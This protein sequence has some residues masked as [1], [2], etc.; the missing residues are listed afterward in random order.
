MLSTHE[1][2]DVVERLREWLVESNE[3]LD[4]SDILELA[5]ILE[6]KE[7]L[8]SDPGVGLVQL[9]EAFTS[10]R[11]E[12][13][14]HTKSVRTLQDQVGEGLSCLGEAT[15]TLNTA[16]VDA[17]QRAERATMPLI[18]ALLDLDEAL[19][20]ASAMCAR[21]VDPQTDR[22][23]DSLLNKCQA[24]F[25]QLPAWKRVAARF[26]HE[27]MM[28]TTKRW[29][30][31]SRHDKSDEYQVGLRMLQTRLERAFAASQIQRVVCAGKMVDP[32]TMRVVETVRDANRPLGTVLEELRPGYL[33][34]GKVLRHA[35]VKAAGE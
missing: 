35:E 30:T 34:A 31:E 9:A 29:Q 12:I 24:A 28:Q 2:N 18:E 26:W 22:P 27:E 10:L 5:D 16:S 3:E 13:K 17:Q 23:A 25:D 1:I 7:Q 19:I 11:H 32:Q 15:T 4:N 14:L 33:R 6:S 20:Q 8:T 21:N